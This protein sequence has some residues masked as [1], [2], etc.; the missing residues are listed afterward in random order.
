MVIIDD[1]E[2]IH[3]PMIRLCELKFKAAFQCGV[4]V[5]CYTT[6]R[7]ALENI[8]RVDP[9]IVF[10]DGELAK[11]TGEY[12]EGANVVRELRE[13][14]SKVII[15]TFSYDDNMNQDMIKSGASILYNKSTSLG[16]IMKEIGTRLRNAGLI[17]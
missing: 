6:A 16:D 5:I 17:T 7:E 13:K 11:D 2:G 10:V 14:M 1:N 4:N 15:I 12:R 9:Q 3:E 8:D